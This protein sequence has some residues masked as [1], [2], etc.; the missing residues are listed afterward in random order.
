M[1]R[2]LQ[3]PLA[4]AVLEGEFSDGDTIMADAGPNDTLVFTHGEAVPDDEPEGVTA[5]A[6]GAATSGAGG[7]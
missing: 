7:R 2:L 5:A 3:N 6:A 1:Q 4:M